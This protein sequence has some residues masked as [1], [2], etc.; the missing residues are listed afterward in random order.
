MPIK[1]CTLPSGKKGYKWGDAGKCYANRADAVRQGAAAHASGYGKSDGLDDGGS[2]MNPSLFAR[3][4]KVD[5]EKRLVFGRVTAEEV[6]RADEVFDYEGSKPY[7]EQ[8]SKEQHEASGGKSYGNVRAMHG[9]TAAGIVSE[10]LKF[11]DAAKTIDAVS[12]IVDDDEW[13]KVIS[14]TYTGYSLGGKYMDRQAEKMGG[15]DIVRYKAMPSE[16][17]LVDRPCVPSATFFDMVK[18]DGSVVHVDFAKTEVV[19]PE[20]EPKPE[21][22]PD[23]DGKVVKQQ[24]TCAVEKHEHE[25][26]KSAQD[27]IADVE[28]KLEAGE[29]VEGVRAEYL[30]KRD[31]KMAGKV[32]KPAAQEVHEYPVEGTDEEVAALAAL[33]SGNKMTVGDAVKLMQEQISARNKVEAAEAQKIGDLAELVKTWSTWAGD[34]AKCSDKL[35]DVEQGAALSVWLA[36]KVTGVWVGSNKPEDSDLEAFIKSVTPETVRKV[37]CIAKGWD[38]AIKVG[39]GMYDVGT[40]ASIIDSL[41]WLCESVKSSNLYAEV[42][43]VDESKID[44]ALNTL[45]ALLGDLV[46]VESER[47]L[48]F[49]EDELRKIGARNNKGDKGRIQKMHDMAVELGAD[50]S[51]EKTDKPAVEAPAPESE[52]TKAISAATAPIQDKLEKLL[53]ENSE[54]ATKLATIAAQ[55]AAPRGILKVVSKQQDSRSAL[56]SEQAEVEPITARDGTVNDVATAIKAV[57]STG[58]KTIR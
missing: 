5:E 25:D 42:G 48:A 12:H 47:I 56:K 32:V 50:C 26:E 41:K 30:K 28:K 34:Y 21:P 10:P 29:T 13:K 22:Q 54:M 16:I 14:G 31:D 57:H 46:S 9:A 37:L 53:K 20:P 33:L 51:T 27:C 24:W 44:S 52:L 23:A 7:F 39:K 58:G 49:D 6:D 43:S 45:I 36:H 19:A 15:K 1:S 3:I 40:L 2:A 55:P 38:R 8:W 4:Y 35:K 17:S 18:A 11:D